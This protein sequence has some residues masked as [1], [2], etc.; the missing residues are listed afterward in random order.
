MAAQLS[1]ISKKLVSN[2][3]TIAV[4]ESV[5]A[6]LVQAAFSLS[7]N[8][9][10]FFQGG[11]TTYNIDQKVAHLKVNRRHARKYNCV[12]RKVAGQMATGVSRL[13]QSDWGAG[14][15]GYA[16]PVPEKKIY[17][18]YAWIA[19]SKNGRI[20]RSKKINAPALSP[21]KTQAYYKQAFIKLLKEVV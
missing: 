9:L 19:I 14:I 12:S 13:F 8:S 18:L 7:K 5:T 1:E 3:T 20:I 21:Q 16:S 6:G 10:D 15:T 11:I 2:K 17:K 4:A